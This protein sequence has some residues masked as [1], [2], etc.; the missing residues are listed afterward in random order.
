MAKYAWCTDPHLDHLN[1]D[2]ARLINF[3][4][5]LIASNPDGVLI[6][7]DISVSRKLVYHLQALEQVVRRP[8]FFV[9]GNHDYYGADIAALR[10]GMKD[11]TNQ[12]QFLK[13]VPT[14]PYVAL[15][16]GTALVGA[17][18]WYDALYGDWQNSSFAMTDWTAIHDF[19]QVNG[20]K[21]TIV[22]LARKL[23]HEAVTHVQEGIKQA[24]RYHK[25]IIV[26]THYPPYPESH[27][28]EGKVGDRFAMPW[29]TSKFMGDMLT[30]AAK[31]YPA[32]SF[33]VLCGHTHGAWS[34]QPYPNMRL[35]VGGA[36][37][38]APR[39][40]GIIDAV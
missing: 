40:A 27:V 25:N 5:E 37:Y 38:G 15:T 39:V 24:V 12:S 28:H 35:H 8:I 6:T 30:A 9:L 17:D 16:P 36:E 10:K 11:L 26:M 14:T 33:T 21:A 31:A 3:S 2:Q 34:G 19:L 32:T 29:F 4:R 22:G 18:G 1:E 7:G 13:Y 20:N 23:A